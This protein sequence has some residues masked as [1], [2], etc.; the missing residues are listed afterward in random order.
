MSRIIMAFV[1]LI[2]VAT[3]AHAD[4]DTPG[5]FFAKYGAHPSP[6]IMLPSVHGRVAA[7]SI[8]AMVTAAAH[9]HGVPVGLAHAVIRIESGYRCNARNGRAQGIGQVFRA[10]ANSVGVY[11][12]L[13]DCSIGLEAAMRYLKLSINMHGAGCAGASGYNTGIYTRSRCTGYGRK[14]IQLA[15]RI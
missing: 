15:G 13:F 4:E 2:C 5:V 12:N 1:A 3:L 7:G 9:R 6:A 11:G 10:T 14:V 8:P